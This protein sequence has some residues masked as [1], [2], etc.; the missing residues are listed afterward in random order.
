[1][2]AAAG[3]VVEAEP[4]LGFLDSVLDVGFRAVPRFELVCVALLVIGDEHV[5]VVGAVVE[6]ELLAW[7]TG[8]RRTTKRR[9]RCQV[10]GCQL[11]PATSLPSR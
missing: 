1:V 6:A 7:A 11:K 4:E 8:S 3:E 9:A 10:F 5:V 2:E